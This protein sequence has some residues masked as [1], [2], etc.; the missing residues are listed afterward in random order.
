MEAARAGV[1]DCFE[2]CMCY[3]LFNEL[4]GQERSMIF[5]SN[6]DKGR[7]GLA[8]AIGYYGSNGYTVSVPLNDTQDYDLIVDDGA[9]LSKVQVKATSQ[10]TK[11]GHT[12]VTVASSGGRG[13]GKVYKTVKDSDADVMFVVTELA[14]MYEVPVVDITGRKCFCLGPD[15]QGYRVDNI[16]TVY[17]KKVPRKPDKFCEVCGDSVNRHNVTGLCKSCAMKKRYG[18][19]ILPKVCMSE[20]EASG[21]SGEL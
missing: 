7:T 13:N 6:K 3:D 2:K 11:D 17:D 20:S 10:R 8:M 1:K 4:A 18:K 21:V 5:D 16:G 14:E 15:R 19:E 9:C 12:V